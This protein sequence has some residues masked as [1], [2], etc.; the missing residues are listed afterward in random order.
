MCLH[1]YVYMYTSIIHT[2]YIYKKHL[3][4][5]GILVYLSYKV[6]ASYGE[7]TRKQGDRK[8]KGV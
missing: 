7:M 6:F 2:K 1:I 8:P 3:H 4:K 5:S